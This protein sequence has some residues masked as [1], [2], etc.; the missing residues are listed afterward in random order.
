MGWIGALVVMMA[1]LAA[2]GAVVLGRNLTHALV[3]AYIFIAAMAL[4]L[5]L[6]EIGPVGWILV[7]ASA[8]ALCLVQVFGWMLVDVDQDHLPPTDRTTIA[9]RGLAFLLLG[10]SL[11][12]LVFH[13]RDELGL[14]AEQPPYPLATL[15]V[16]S[17]VASSAPPR[18]AAIGEALFATLH[19]HSILLGLA[20]ATALL[21]GLL[22]LREET[23]EERR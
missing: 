2:L 12:L 7:I 5:S 18:A 21:V 1:W 8:S 17:S 19:S 14:M 11:A 6:A 10:V 20:I 3:S 16:A 9:A 22:L 4:G 23:G 13:A 15:S